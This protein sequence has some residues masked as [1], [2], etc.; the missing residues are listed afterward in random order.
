MPIQTAFSNTDILFFNFN[1]SYVKFS[2]LPIYYRWLAVCSGVAD[3]AIRGGRRV[4]PNGDRKS[5]RRFGYFGHTY[6]CRVSIHH[7]T[8]D[9]IYL[10]IL[11]CRS[12]AGTCAQC[13]N[14]SMY[15]V[16]TILTMAALLSIYQFIDLDH[17]KYEQKK[18]HI[19][20]S[21]MQC[22]H[23]KTKRKKFNFFKFNFHSIFHLIFHAR[24]T[25]ALA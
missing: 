2:I 22:E 11:V 6:T 8:T 7:Y 19:E 24:H 17:E 3:K 18:K 16:H 21:N 20:S 15:I 10:L 13:P 12:M 14:T 23:S 5:V 4:R 1:Y 9:H 25:A